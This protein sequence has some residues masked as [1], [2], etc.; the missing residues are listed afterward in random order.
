MYSLQSPNIVAK[1]IANSNPEVTINIENK[2][3]VIDQDN[4]LFAVAMADSK[5]SP[6]KNSEEKVYYTV[7]FYFCQLG[8]GLED[9]VIVSKNE[10]ID[11]GSQPCS[12][13][14]IDPKLLQ[15]KTSD[16]DR[17]YPLRANRLP[18]VLIKP[19][20]RKRWK[21]L[22]FKVFIRQLSGIT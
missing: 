15:V 7:G 2:A 19:P 11:L 22:N 1:T 4:F 6:L 8:Y 17:E 20:G 9:G 13:I 16:L 14:D 5:G 3:F 10:C 18:N 21:S 12:T